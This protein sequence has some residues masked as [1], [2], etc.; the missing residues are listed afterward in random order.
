MDY[1][2]G[3]GKVCGLTSLV[4]C[5]SERRRVS[6]RTFGMTVSAQDKLRDCGQQRQ[7]G[8]ARLGGSGRPVV[9]LGLL[10]ACL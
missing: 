1:I 6:R 2:I 9:L 3:G 5:T 4:S 7:A 10:T 8:G